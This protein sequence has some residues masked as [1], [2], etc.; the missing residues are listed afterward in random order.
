[1][2]ATQEADGVTSV[3]SLA[4]VGTLP[5]Q[6]SAGDERRAYGANEEGEARH[7]EVHGSADIRQI[8]EELAPR[9]LNG[10]SRALGGVE[11][12]PDLDHLVD[13]GAHAKPQ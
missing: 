10:V 11:P 7:E 9:Y 5:G 13:P 6:K 12:A 4:A 8:G 3:R 1:M 2:L